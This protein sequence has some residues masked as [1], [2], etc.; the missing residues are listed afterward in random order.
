MYVG[1]TILNSHRWVAA[2]NKRRRIRRG[3]T[4]FYV[5]DLSSDEANFLFLDFPSCLHGHDLDKNTVISLIILW[6]KFPKFIILPPFFKKS[7]LLC[8]SFKFHCS[9]SA[10]MGINEA[11]LKIRVTTFIFSPDSS[12][13]AFR[14]PWAK[15]PGHLIRPN[16]L[17]VSRYLA[18]VIPEIFDSHAFNAI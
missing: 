2:V 16:I 10:K 1:K 8:T 4:P 11:G 18:G 13:V 12:N 6:F 9:P 3:W 7:Q 14:F 15:L 5:I 17:D